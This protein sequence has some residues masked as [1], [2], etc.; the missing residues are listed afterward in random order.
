MRICSGAS[1]GSG[2]SFADQNLK[3]EAIPTTLD[4]V[5]ARL[6]LHTCTSPSRGGSSRVLR[7]TLAILSTRQ[8]LSLQS[9]APAGAFQ[10]FIDSG[11][12]SAVSLTEDLS[13]EANFYSIA[14]R[15]VPSWLVDN[16]RNS[17]AKANAA[18][19]FGP[20]E[21]VSLPNVQLPWQCEPELHLRAAALLP[22]FGG[23]GKSVVDP[24]NEV[25]TYT[26]FGLGKALFST[27]GESSAVTSRRFYARP[28]VGYGIIFFP[29]CGYLVGVEWIG[30]LLMYPVSEPFFLGSQ[31]HRAAVS[32]LERFDYSESVELVAPPS[33]SKVWRS[34]P[35]VGTT[36]VV[37][38]V[39]AVNGKFYK[40]I[41][42]TAFDG[43]SSSPEDW[44][45]RLYHT[46]VAYTKAFHNAPAGD[47]PPPSLVE[48]RLLYGAFA[49]LV[50]M[51]FVG[52]ATVSEDALLQ[53]GHALGEVAAA[54]A[55]LARR[56]LLYID[57]RPQNVVVGSSG[58]H[59]LIDYDDVLVLPAPIATAKELGE[60]LEKHCSAAIVK[61]I[62]PPLILELSTHSWS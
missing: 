45:R 23:E 50:E 11:A 15:F 59:F 61:S 13:K 51:P 19:L 5:F 56:G 39:E 4:A 54:V 32:A 10:S 58:Q 43:M 24:F 36:Q 21:S 17:I 1:A 28:P 27:T 53:P 7:S 49:M 62:L 18:V 16:Q 30:K 38:T 42:C 57:L 41:E 34:W 31:S 25:L 3:T 55:W 20:P 9:N 37:W 48:A 26:L 47:A 52:S 6:Q 29:H 40:M 14:T 60:A 22:P 12:V 8:P 46:Y 33:S 2:S 44:L 35:N